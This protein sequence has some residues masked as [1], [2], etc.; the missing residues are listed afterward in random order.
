MPPNNPSANQDIRGFMSPARTPRNR[1][2]IESDSSEEIDLGGAA[3][4]PN[5]Q[6]R[7]HLPTPAAQRD[8]NQPP[9]TIEIDS[10]SESSDSMYV[11][12]R[13]R[14]RVENAQEDRN[15]RELQLAPQRHRKIP[16][17]RLRTPQRQLHQERSTH[18]RRLLGEAESTSDEASTGL[19]ADESDQNA[20]DLYRSAIMGV[21][22]RPIAAHQ[23][24]HTRLTTFLIT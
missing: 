9:H 22:N 24:C 10:D 1:R 18:Q 5:R 7:P 13:S 20:A 11:P 17:R 16:Q 6:L 23:V 2:I 15:G 4:Q 8:E 12:P 21:R 19:T 14:A 3:A